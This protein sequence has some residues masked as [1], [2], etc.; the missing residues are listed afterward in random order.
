MPEHEWTEHIAK[1]KRQKITADVF[2]RH[3]VKPHQYKCICK[4]D[5]VIE[6]RLRGHQNKTEKRT[7]PML[8]HNR[9][10]DFAPRR[11]RASANARGPRLVVAGVGDPGGIP[12]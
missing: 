8:V 11:M 5:R 9:V 4:K 1:C 3:A 7:L 12:S 10:P 6:K 2:L